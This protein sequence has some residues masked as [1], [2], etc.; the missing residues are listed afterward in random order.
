MQISNFLTQRMS[1]YA[2]SFLG[3]IMSSNNDLLLDAAAFREASTPRKGIVHSVF[4]ALF[5]GLADAADWWHASF[6]CIS[7]TSS[8]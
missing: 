7:L 3:I 6:F 1:T 4:T 5:G 2:M 8:L